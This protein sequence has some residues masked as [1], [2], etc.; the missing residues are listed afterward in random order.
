ME[1]DKGE[2]I[3]DDNASLVRLSPN[4]M[5]FPIEKNK[6]N[7]IFCFFDRSP[8]FGKYAFQIILCNSAVPLFHLIFVIFLLNF[9]RE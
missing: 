6:E 3:R 4:P 1:N 9:Q 5:L 7:A 2:F 8:C